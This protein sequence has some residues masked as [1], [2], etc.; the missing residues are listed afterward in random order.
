MGKGKKSLYTAMSAIAL[1]G[2][3]GLVGLFV[4]KLIIEVYGSDFNGLNSTT[5]QFINMLMIVEGGFTLA[6]NVALFEPLAKKDYQTVNRILSATKKIFI[7]IGLLFFVLGTLFSVFYIFLIKSNLSLITI[8]LVFFMAVFSTSF[9]LTFSV[10]YKILLQSEQK[11][12]ILNFVQIF[13]IIIS[14]IGILAIIFLDKNM[15]L[16]RLFVMLGAILNSVLVARICRKNYSFVDFNAEPDYSKV[17]GTRDVFAQKL[18]TMIYQTIPVLFISATSG[19]VV[20]SVYMIYNNVFGLFKNIL[21]SF[22]NAPQMGFGRLIKEKTN[23]YVK[24]IFFE[25]EFIVVFLLG[26][27]L[28]TCHVLIIPFIEIFTRKMTDANYIDSSLAFMFVIITF[29]EI[30]HIPSGIIINMSGNFKVA[31]SFQM[32][33]SIALLITMYPLS[34][35]YSFYGILFSIIIAALLLAILEIFYVHKYY[36]KNSLGKFM[37]IVCSNFVISILSIKWQYYLIGD[38]Q[39]YKNFFL[40]GFILVIINTV[41][42]ILFNLILNKK[43]M[44]LVINRLKKILKRL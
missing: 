25:Y 41:Y 23:Q 40:T 11:E 7:K 13:T 14:Q 21:Y 39:S 26:I 37:W 16:I 20:A 33:V 5:T 42:F 30:I 12:Y 1:T 44:L 35:I 15:L 43:E 36:F 34:K 4:T 19:T 3:N 17:K 22:I 28:T 2:I 6:T 27:L 32:I 29:L 31:K 9:N 24:K 10:K 8:F 38:I 18:T